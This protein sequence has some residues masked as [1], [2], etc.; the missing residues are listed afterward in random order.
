MRNL[1]NRLTLHSPS[2]G[3]A[4]E[5]GATCTIILATQ[6]KLP[7]STTQCLTGG[8]IGVGLCSGTWRS[9]NWRMVAWVYGGWVL[10]LPVAGLLSGALCGIIINAPRWGYVSS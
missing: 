8:V 2:R 5:L 9:I 7:V 4:M 3:F 6:L 1:G 10:T